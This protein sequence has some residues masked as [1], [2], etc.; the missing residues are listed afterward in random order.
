MKEPLT[1]F[2]LCLVV[3]TVVTFVAFHRPGDSISFYIIL[4]LGLML[5]ASVVAV[6]SCVARADRQ[7][8]ASSAALEERVGDLTRELEHATHLAAAANHAKSEFMSM[9]SH[10]IRT[11]MNGVLGVVDALA[12]T[13]LTTQQQD[14]IDSI[15]DSADSLQKILSDILDLSII[16]SG[17]I[18]LHHEDFFLD[19][20]LESIQSLW[21]P[22]ALARLSQLRHF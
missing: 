21:R 7:Q 2:A 10:E 11:P 3:L 20:L 4:I 22:A 18:E 14:F 6:L 5:A 19:A 17:R 8:A 15:R 16:E 13:E 1:R 9:I 12:K